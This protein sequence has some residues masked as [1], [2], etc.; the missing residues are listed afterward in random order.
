MTGAFAQ[1]KS[2]PG[3]QLSIGLDFGVPINDFADIHS[4]GFGG[5]GKA[6][7]PVSAAFDITLTAGYISYYYDQPYKNALKATGGDTYLGFVP[8]KV[9]GKYYFSRN[10]YGEGEIGARIG[11]NKSTGTAFIYAPG[12]GLSYPVGNKHDLDFGVRFEGWT[13]DSNVQQFVFRLAYKFGM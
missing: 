9:G 7:L 8:L 6:E 12:L 3:P 1:R 4:I 11:T 2:S 5:S 10:V 13:E